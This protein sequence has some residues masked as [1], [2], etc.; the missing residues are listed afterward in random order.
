MVIIFI[1]V[2][3]MIILFHHNDHLHYCNYYDHYQ[4]FSF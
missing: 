4:P 2:I 1:I 3:I